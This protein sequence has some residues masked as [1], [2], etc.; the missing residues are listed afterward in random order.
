MFPDPL[1]D[2][3]NELNIIHQLRPIRDD[4]DYENA[5]AVVDQLAVLDRRTHDQDDYLETLSDLIGKYDQIQYTPQLD[6]L[7][8]I[9]SLKDLLEQ[10]ELSPPQLGEILSEP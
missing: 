10:N 1:P 7:S 8:P 4:I 2:T 3:F 5:V 6:H 9:Q